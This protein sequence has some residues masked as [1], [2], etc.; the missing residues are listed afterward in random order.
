MNKT[1]EDYFFEDWKELLKKNLD[2]HV[3]YLTNGGAETYADYMLYV[4]KITEI[5]RTLAETDQLL[6]KY[7]PQ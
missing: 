1:V 5:K 7:Y 3:E 2:L 4:V 6:D